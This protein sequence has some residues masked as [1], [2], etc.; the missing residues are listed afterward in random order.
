[1]ATVTKEIAD[2][3]VAGEFKEDGWVRIV[4]YD[5]AWGGTSYGCETKWELGKYTP[6]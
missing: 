3:I 1:M 6:S 5:N 4:E 2:R